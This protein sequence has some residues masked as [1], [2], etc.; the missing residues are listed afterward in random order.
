MSLGVHS[1]VALAAP[2]ILVYLAIT[3]RSRQEWLSALGGAL[4]GVLLAL[5]AFLVLDAI[6]ADAGYYNATVVPSLSVWDMNST[7]F[8]SPFERLTFLYAAKQFNYAMFGAPTRT[9]P[10]IAKIYMNV[11]R[12]IFAPLSL[13]LAGFGFLGVFVPRWR[14]GLLLL[15]G[16]GVQ[17]FFITNYD[18]FDVVVFFVPTYVFLAVWAGVGLGSLMEALAWGVKRFKLEKAAVP[19][20]ALLGIACLGL[21][22]KSWGGMVM[23]AWS[24][25]APIFMRG[26]EFESYPYPLNHPQAARNEA[27]AIVNAVEANAI[28]FLGWDLLFPCYFIAHI[29]QNHHEMDFHETY[30]QEG[31]TEVGRSAADYIE[32]NLP[33]RPVYFLEHPSGTQIRRF[34]VQLV[35]RDG[36]TLYQVVSL[37]PQEVELLVRLSPAFIRGQ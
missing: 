23:D 17:M 3:S 12:E 18:I 31:V 34:E 14:E 22:V 24:A 35:R 33:A 10:F 36:L 27:Q 6:H 4:L 21:T 1:S 32:A 37:R 9:M 2:G 15:L 26:T 13:V 20:T 19:T 5:G 28:V 8:D 29:E 16:W 7:D 30:P 25:R 11:L